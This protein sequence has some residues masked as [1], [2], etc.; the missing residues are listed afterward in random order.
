MIDGN[1]T[2]ALALLAGLVVGGLVAWLYLRG[3]SVRQLTQL[4]NEMRHQA[5]LHVQQLSGLQNRLD[6]VQG[7]LTSAENSRQEKESLLEESR[8]SEAGLSS[9]VQ[10]LNRQ[11]ADLELRINRASEES[12]QLRR[13]NQ[14][15]REQVAH[16]RT[17][18]EAQQKQN[19]EKLLLLKEA[20]EQLNHEFRHVANEIFDAKQKTF[21]EQSQSQLDSMLK[22]LGERIRDFE[23]RVEET[24]NKESKER[25][26]LAKEVRNLQ[27]L[28]TRIS[29]DAVNLT[30]ALKGE[31]KTQ[32][33]WGEV[34]LE[35]VLEKSGLVKG[36]EYE[37]Q[38]SMTSEQGRRLQ[39]DVVVHLPE[40]KDVI[41][42]SKVSL[43]AYERFCSAETDK[44]R[45]DALKAH[46]ASIRQ[47]IKSL[48]AKD[49]QNLAS[50]RTLDFILLFI[51]VEAAFALAVQEDNELFASAFDENIVLVAP[52]TLLATLRIIQNI[53]RYEQQ[54]RNA[55]EI[56]RKAGGLY[57]K[58]VN[59]VADLEDVGVRIN[60]LQKSYDGAHNKLVSGR[61]NLVNRAEAMRLLGAKTSKALDQDLVA[62]GSEPGL[63]HI[64][65]SDDR[66][67]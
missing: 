30:N 39:P 5:E 33:T 34:I 49:Y 8:R 17:S 37:V 26:S 23:K 32:G 54:N 57:D 47:H 67:A 4:E 14:H 62:A 10:L 52:S 11:V 41:I 18:L 46:Q 3:S 66:G 64:D 40:G 44:D 61:G 45:T 2:A 13:D 48:G 29:Q 55:Q 51:P 9:Q 28:N 27:E 38:V 53:W 35:R 15:Q 58:F 59:F 25:F 50:V 19:E 12:E 16:L 56:A 6:D 60:A 63:E 1:E 7:L 36:R 21:R 22:P 42:D 20:R 43:V 65:E 24:Y 31:N